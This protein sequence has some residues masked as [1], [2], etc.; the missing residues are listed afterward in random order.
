VHLLSHAVASLCDWPAVAWQG[1]KSH[2]RRVVPSVNDVRPPA[3]AAR[4]AVVVCGALAVLAMHGLTA[5]GHG[6]HAM[7]EP[8]EPSMATASG[9]TDHGNTHQSDGIHLTDCT[10]AS[11]ACVAIVLSAATTVAA[12]NLRHRWP[13]RSLRHPISVTWQPDPP[14]PRPSFVF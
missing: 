11:A 12:F 1:P 3:F 4:V 8:V 7:S 5:G 9:L 10:T 13:L 2:H 6:A 14:V